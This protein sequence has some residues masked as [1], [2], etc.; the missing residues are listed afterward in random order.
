[1]TPSGEQITGP[2]TCKGYKQSQCTPLFY[3]AY[4]LR[5]AGAVIHTHSTNAV[6]TT[7]ILERM[8]RKVW[9]IT[10][11]EMIKGIRIGSSKDSYRFFDVIEIPVIKNTP[12]EKDLQASM[13]A[14]MEAYPDANAVL[15]ERHGIYVWGETWEKAKSMNEC[16][17]Y[18]LGLTVELHKMGIAWDEE[19]AGST[20]LNEPDRR[21]KS[22]SEE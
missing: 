16:Y 13:R 21:L 8:N 1:M 7:M 18:L 12:E 17:D 20:Y 10:H 5:N 22:T 11:Q 14:A 2:P 6:L 19:P 4:N 15:V 9:R 3:N